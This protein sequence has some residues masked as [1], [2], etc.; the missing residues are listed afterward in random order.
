MKVAFEIPDITPV[1]IRRSLGEEVAGGLTDHE[2]L[3]LWLRH[4]LRP[5][6]RAY[7][8]RAVNLDAEITAREAAETALAVEN[9]ARIVAENRADELAN[10]DLAEVV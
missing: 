1:L 4:Q 5:L 7:R 10:N 9:N 8:H 6:F 3:T 2:I